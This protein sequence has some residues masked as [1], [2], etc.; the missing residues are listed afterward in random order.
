MISTIRTIT[1]R[2]RIRWCGTRASVLKIT[3]EDLLAQQLSPGK[4]LWINCASR[5][6]LVQRASGAVPT[7]DLVHRLMVGK[8]YN[9]QPGKLS[10]PNA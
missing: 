6:A 2:H 7:G 9:K 5:A 3:D 4:I 8:S 10:T 1:C